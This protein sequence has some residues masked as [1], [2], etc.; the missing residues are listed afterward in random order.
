MVLLML[1]FSVAQRNFLSSQ[2]LLDRS[3]S[4][5]HSLTHSNAVKASRKSNA[6]VM[7][8]NYFVDVDFIYLIY[9]FTITIVRIDF[10]YPYIV[11]V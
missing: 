2:S 10:S 3:L 1:M 11:L 5:A 9:L 8:M 4:S 7:V 6:D